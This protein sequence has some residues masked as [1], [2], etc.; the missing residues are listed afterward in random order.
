[1][2]NLAPQLDR[3]LNRQ[4]GRHRVSSP[5]P[6]QSPAEWMTNAIRQGL[7]PA[8]GAQAL[9]RAGVSLSETLQ[10]TSRALSLTRSAV[11]NP[12]KAAATLAAKALG[13]PALPVRLAVAA[14]SAVR[15]IGRALS[16]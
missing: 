3:A 5:A 10:A 2:K 8:H 4:L 7:R 9:A 11:G 6:G 12:A 16:R 1:M 14:L 15:S 13:V